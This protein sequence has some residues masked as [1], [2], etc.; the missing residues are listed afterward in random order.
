MFATNTRQ[1]TSVHY[2][3]DIDVEDLLKVIK[4]DD[5]NIATDGRTLHDHLMNIDAVEEVDYD[6]MFGPHLFFKVDANRDNSHLWEF[7]E[8][9]VNGYLGES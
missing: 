8:Q 5:D 7:V 6:G 4:L 9:V 1:K 3:V 2:C